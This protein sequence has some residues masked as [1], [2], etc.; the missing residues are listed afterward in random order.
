MRSSRAILAAAALAL[1]ACGAE[2]PASKAAPGETAPG[3]A[4]PARAPQAA[5]PTSGAAQAEADGI[6]STRCAVCH[7][8]EGAG[9]GPGS[10]GLVPSPRDLGDPAWQRSVSDE[11]IEKI[12]VYGGAAVGRS[13]TM[14]GNPDLMAKPEVVAAL[15]EHIRGLAPR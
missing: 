8:P 11:H 2:E 3:Q 7:G 13:P 12:I 4:P 6:F 15:R 5:A 1:A 14:P 9:D 10:T